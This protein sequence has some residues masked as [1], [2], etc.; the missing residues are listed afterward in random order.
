MKKEKAE[1]I[2]WQLIAVT[3]DNVE[4]E[5]AEVP[6]WVSAVVDEFL[7]T[8]DLETTKLQMLEHERNQLLFR[9]ANPQIAGW[10]DMD[11]ML[12]DMANNKIKALESEEE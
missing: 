6:N 11:E 1:I 7:N 8:L 5:I 4:H 12:L 10:D 9:K 3:E 2:A